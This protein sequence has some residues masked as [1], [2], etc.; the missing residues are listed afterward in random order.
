MY[1]IL[2]DLNNLDNLFLKISNCPISDNLHSDTD[3]VLPSRQRLT[4][5]KGAFH[6]V[7]HFFG[8]KY[9]LMQK[10]QYFKFL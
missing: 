5:R 2:N 1:K 9:L 4:L 10:S 8:I 7:A 6:I 3:L